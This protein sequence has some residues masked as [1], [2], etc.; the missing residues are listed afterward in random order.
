MSTATT[1]IIGATLGGV[2]GMLYG[3]FI[4]NGSRGYSVHPLN[5]RYAVIVTS[6]WTGALIGISLGAVVVVLRELQF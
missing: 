1:L 4:A 5:R 2:I 3:Y 6:T